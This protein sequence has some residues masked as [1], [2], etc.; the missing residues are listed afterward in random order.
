MAELDHRVRN[1]LASIRSIL[2][3]AEKSAQSKEE[4]AE[5][6]RGRVDAM[7][8]AHGLLTNTQW[9]GA[10]LRRLVADELQPY[11]AGEAGRLRIAGSDI[12]LQPKAAVL[13]ALVVHE[14]ATNAAKYGALS[15]AS[16]TVSVAWRID[17]SHDDRRLHLSWSES[18]G[19]P[20]AKPLRRGFGTLLIENSLA[21]EFDATVRLDFAPGGVEFRAMI[22][23]ARI[24]VGDREPA[25]EEQAPPLASPPPAIGLSGARVLLVEDDALIA[26]DM[27][28]G[29]EQA[30][31]T[32][33]GPVARLDRALLLAADDGLDAAV[34]DVNLGGEHV[35]PL[36]DLLAERSIPFAFLTGY[37]RRAVFPDRYRDALALQK[38]IS[39][40]ALTA[41]V[42]R[43]MRDQARVAS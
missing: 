16:G 31:A 34:L 26:L 22:P 2:T 10:N 37:H 35:F 9:R 39:R 32:I 43:L 33:V 4:F 30:G 24:A 20:V 29:L 38:P 28:D 21:Q 3:L 1:T 41:V 42:E 13:I 5:G 27:K 23:L 36:A 14:L 8:R 7:A 6:V 12:L 15:V 40:P 11:M 19:P 17:R 18:G 25:G